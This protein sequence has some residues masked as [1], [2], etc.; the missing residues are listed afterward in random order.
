MYINT[1][2]Y[3][4]NHRNYRCYTGCYGD[5]GRRFLYSPVA[6]FSLRIRRLT[7]HVIGLNRRR[8]VQIARRE[9]GAGETAAY[10]VLVPKNTAIGYIDSE[11]SRYAF[12]LKDPSASYITM[13]T[14]GVFPMVKSANLP[15]VPLVLFL[16]MVTRKP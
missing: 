11:S 2:I 7:G 10:A 12:I 9:G 4:M 13:A 15:M 16:P 3:K 5:E 8:P 14:L 6:F 1:I